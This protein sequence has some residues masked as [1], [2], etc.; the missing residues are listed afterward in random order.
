MKYHD[1]DLPDARLADFCR[2]NRIARLS[3]YGSILTERFN[4][5]SDVD[6]LVEFE[7]G[8]RIS[9]LDVARM[10]IELTEM[11]GRKVD[12]RSPRDLSP[13]FRDEVLRQAVVQYVR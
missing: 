5:E 7:P 13:Y 6:L 1:V 3:L 9:L 4:P 2:V 12:L 10:E 11:L 8:A